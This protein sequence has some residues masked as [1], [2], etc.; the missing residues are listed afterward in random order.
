VEAGQPG[1]L[2]WR[3]PQISELVDLSLVHSVLIVFNQQNSSTQPGHGYP[4]YLKFWVNRPR[5]SEIADFEPIFARSASAVTPSER[6]QL[7]LIGSPLRAF[8]R[9]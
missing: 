9:D 6:V 8:Q 4:F 5:C 1:L 7:T 3:A 2:Y